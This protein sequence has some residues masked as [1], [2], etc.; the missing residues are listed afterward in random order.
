[1]AKQKVIRKHSKKGAPTLV[2]VECELWEGKID[3]P[4]FTDIKIGTREA[5]L[6]SGQ[7][8]PI[9]DILEEH[10]EGMKELIMDSTDEEL[11]PVIEAWVKVSQDGQEDPKSNG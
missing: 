5:L 4:R 7:W 6:V 10:A 9:A 3:L 2:S 1:M 8:G 11:A